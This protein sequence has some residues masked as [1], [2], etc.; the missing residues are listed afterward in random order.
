MES[1]KEEIYAY[2]DGVGHQFPVLTK[3]PLFWHGDAVFKI[4]AFS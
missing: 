4:R 3:V 1:L 2:T